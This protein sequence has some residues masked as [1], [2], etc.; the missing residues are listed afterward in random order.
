M[1]NNYK[2]KSITAATTLIHIIGCIFHAFELLD[3]S[4][5]SH[6]YVLPALIIILNALFASTIKYKLAENKNYFRIIFLDPL[7][8]CLIIPVNMVF[9]KNNQMN[10]C[11]AVFAGYSLLPFLLTTKKLLVDRALKKQLSAYSKITI[12]LMILLGLFS[13]ISF[14]VELYGIIFG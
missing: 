5:K 8:M 7:C 9:I 11:F 6:S 4:L 1:N 10:L 12:A 13:V 3:G 2:I 14:A